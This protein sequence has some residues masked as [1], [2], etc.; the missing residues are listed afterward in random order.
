MV[1]VPARRLLPLLLGLALLLLAGCEDEE[2][3]DGAPTLPETTAFHEHVRAVMATYP[4]DGTHGYHWPRPD[5]GSWLGFT[6]TILYA[7]EILG[8]G[9]PQGRCHCSGLTLEVFLRAWE[10]WCTAKGRP[11][12]ILDLD[13][14]GVRRFQRQWFGTSGDRATLCTALVENGLGFRVTDRE[15]ARK[16]DFVQLWRHSGSGHSCVFLD[17]VREDGRIVGLSYWSTQRATNGIGEREERFG[18]DGSS[19]KADELYVVRVGRR[20]ADR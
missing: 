3:G 12:R 20:P 16:G 9:D 8:R 13:L 4:Q 10:R 7:G 19:V 15:A 5:D 1:P 14:A 2:G 11:Y 17:W 18:E 6:R